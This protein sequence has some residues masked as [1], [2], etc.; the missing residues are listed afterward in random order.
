MK[1]KLSIPAFLNT[2]EGG[3]D[4]IYIGTIEFPYRGMI[5]FH[6]GS[7]NLEALHD[8][9]EKL[10]IRKWF[11]D[12]DDHLHPHYDICKSKKSQALKLGA[13]EVDDREL[14]NRC[15]PKLKNFMA[16]GEL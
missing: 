6:M 14:I 15:Y 9:A 2:T 1:K 13:V 16:G 10:G 4:T 5:M 3:P 7:P 8:M 11:Q 12:D